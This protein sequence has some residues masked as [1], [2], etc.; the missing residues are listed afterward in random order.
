MVFV[1]ASLGLKARRNPILASLELGRVC[2][3]RQAPDLR[4]R[5]VLRLQFAKNQSSVTAKNQG[6]SR[7]TLPTAGPGGE[8]RVVQWPNQSFP[9]V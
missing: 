4:D 7:G 5:E 2:G 9:I 8:H 6:A 1:R 3:Q